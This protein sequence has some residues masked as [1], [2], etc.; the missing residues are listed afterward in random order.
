[1]SE[2]STASERVNSLG[3]SGLGRLKLC[4][5]LVVSQ[6]LAKSGS[7]SGSNFLLAFARVGKYVFQICDPNL[8]LKFSQSQLGLFCFFEEFFSKCGDLKIK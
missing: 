8:P 4:G 3:F 7:K 5:D 6:R 2:M 1:M